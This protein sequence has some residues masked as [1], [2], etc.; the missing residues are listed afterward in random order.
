MSNQINGRSQQRS[1]TKANWTLLNPV[2]LA[3][4]IGYEIDT[5]KMKIGNGVNAWNQLLYYGSGIEGVVDADTLGGHYPSDFATAEQGIK[6]DNALPATG[7]AVAASKLATERTITLAGDVTGSAAFDGSKNITIN[8]TVTNSDAEI[9]IDDVTDLRDIL[10]DKVN[11]NQVLTNVPYDAKFT[12]TIYVHPETHSADIL[13][14]GQTNKVYTYTEKTKLSGIAP[15]ATKVAKSTINGNI[16][17]NSNEVN[18]YTHP[19]GTNPHGLTKADIGLENVNNTSDLDKPI[20]T[21]TQNALN[22]KIDVSR[23]ND[24]VVGSNLWTSQ[25]IYD[26]LQNSGGAPGDTL[27]Y[28]ATITSAPTTVNITIPA[29]SDYKSNNVDVLLLR[30]SRWDKAIH[31]ID[32][33]Y[34]FTSQTNLQMEF[35]EVGSYKINYSFTAVGNLTI[36]ETSATEPSMQRVGDI[37]YKIL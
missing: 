17:I 31:G 11:S 8:T 24:E 28:S 27:Q 18:V 26:S 5:N 35:L 13:V 25:K 23:I 33:I 15:A 1:N 19:A 7:T 14:D 20:S 16:L 32:Y 22:A 29:M 36:I 3:G 10:N 6:A 34:G 21:A 4:E 2:L 37:W 12:D 30:G 9:T